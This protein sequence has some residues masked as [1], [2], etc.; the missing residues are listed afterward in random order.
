MT[1]R[2]PRLD[3]WP[4]P[5]SALPPRTQHQSLPVS[6]ATAL[7]TLSRE[8]DRPSRPPPRA[9]PPAS[10]PHPPRPGPGEARGPPPLALVPPA[11]RPGNGGVGPRPV[12]PH[13]NPPIL[14]A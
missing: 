8:R 5:S 10:A 4:P 12:E 7:D 1:A 14:F 9:R 13:L 6:H 11:P 2:R 3:P